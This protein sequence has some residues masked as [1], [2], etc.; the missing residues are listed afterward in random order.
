MLMTCSLVDNTYSLS[1]VCFDIIKHVV[2]LLL[3]VE[4]RKSNLS[5]R[6]VLLSGLLKHKERLLH[7]PI[8]SDALRIAVVHIHYLYQV[9]FQRRKQ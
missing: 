9:V 2:P 1:P 5:F 8:N 7:I 4:I 3:P 6:E